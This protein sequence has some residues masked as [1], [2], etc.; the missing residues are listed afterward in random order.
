M[1]YLVFLRISGGCNVALPGEVVFKVCRRDPKTMVSWVLWSA[2]YS[3]MIY[4]IFTSLD[5]TASCVYIGFELSAQKI[6]KS[7]VCGGGAY[8]S[9]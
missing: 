9:L 6:N 4:E 5:W 3:F 7:T 8:R 2:L 1:D